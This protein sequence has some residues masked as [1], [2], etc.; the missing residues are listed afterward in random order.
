MT[1]TLRIS[2]SSLA[3]KIWSLLPAAASGDLVGAGHL[4]V[5]YGK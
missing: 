4:I 1:A 5:P 2:R 3:C